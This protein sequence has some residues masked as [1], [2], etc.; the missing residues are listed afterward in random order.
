MSILWSVA[1]LGTRESPASGLPNLTINYTIVIPAQAGIH[2]AT[3]LH[4]Y[5]DTSL[6]RCDG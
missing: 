4:R 6:R 5:L 2:H 1:C 3:Q